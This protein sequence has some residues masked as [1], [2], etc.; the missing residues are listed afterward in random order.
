[1]YVIS[2]IT[3]NINIGWTCIAY[4]F[5]HRY[6]RWS[7]RL[8]FSKRISFFQLLSPRTQWLRKDFPPSSYY[9]TSNTRRWIY[10]VEHNET[11]SDWLHATGKFH[12]LRI[13]NYTSK[14]ASVCI[15][16]VQRTAL[17]TALCSAS[18]A[19]GNRKITLREV[20]F[21]DKTN[22]DLISRHRH[23][24]LQLFWKS[25]QVHWCSYS[26]RQNDFKYLPT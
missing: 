9:R 24:I 12:F 21:L 25:M 26:N 20:R 19:R 10:S 6:L 4:F 17:S 22:S 5:C 2:G 14:S 18:V 3:L 7:Y 16:W 8:M 23:I 1:M 11:F 15:F 13:N